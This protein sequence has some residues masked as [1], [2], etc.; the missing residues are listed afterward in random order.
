MTDMP[1]RDWTFLDPTAELF[2]DVPSRPW[3]V[4]ATWDKER[5]A[6]NRTLR[7]GATTRTPRL[8]PTQRW[9]DDNNAERA[10]PAD[11]A[12]RSFAAPVLWDPTG[13]A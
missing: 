8:L 7:A 12:R 6:F 4:P 2:R 13:T 11:A 9:A 10:R 1:V 5:R 3:A